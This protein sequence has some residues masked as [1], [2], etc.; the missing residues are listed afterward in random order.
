[1][2]ALPGSYRA[3]LW[4]ASSYNTVGSTDFPALEPT[5]SELSINRENPY[6]QSL[7]PSRSWGDRL[8]HYPLSILQD[9]Y[10]L[11]RT[12]FRGA[13]LARRASYDYLTQTVEACAEWC[14]EQARV[15]LGELG[16]TSMREIFIAAARLRIVPKNLGE[17]LAS[18]AD[19]RNLVTHENV[20]ADE[21][22]VVYDRLLQLALVGFATR[23]AVEASAGSP[24]P[25]REPTRPTFPIVVDRDFVRA[26]AD[27]FW[28]DESIRGRATR[29]LDRE[30]FPPR[31]VIDAKRARS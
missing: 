8:L 24:G 12:E 19:L 1:L 30:P 18:L 25:S 2:L 13:N 16:Q 15:A 9:I 17:D 22:L 23:F 6:S 3:H 27:R 4:L 26:R 7:R 31:Y 14:R 28:R 21:A 10:P 5:G 20:R 11:S 29:R